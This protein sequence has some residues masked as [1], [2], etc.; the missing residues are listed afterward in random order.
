M[1]ALVSGQAIPEGWHQ[2]QLER[3]QQYLNFIAY[4]SY[5]APGSVVRAPGSNHHG[6]DNRLLIIVDAKQS[7]SVN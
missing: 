5:V 2:A 4:G 7:D 1:A 6:M 3:Q